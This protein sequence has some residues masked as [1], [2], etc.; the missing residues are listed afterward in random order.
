MAAMEDKLTDATLWNPS[1]PGLKVGRVL[2]RPLIIAGVDDPD[3]RYMKR[4][5]AQ[6]DAALLSKVQMQV[7]TSQ[8]DQQLLNQPRSTK[9]N[10]DADEGGDALVRGS[11]LPPNKA[12]GWKRVEIPDGAS[13]V[14]KLETPRATD[15]AEKLGM[16]A[17]EL[18]AASKED[19]LRH[20]GFKSPVGRAIP[21]EE[22]PRRIR[23]PMRIPTPLQPEPELDDGS[24][25]RR[26]RSVGPSVVISFSPAT[27]ASPEQPSSPSIR[28]AVIQSEAEAEHSSWEVTRRRV[29]Q[30]WHEE[31][32]RQRSDGSERDEL[33]GSDDFD[34]QVRI[35]RTFLSIAVRP[36]FT[37]A[38]RQFPVKISL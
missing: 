12:D 23:R 35:G 30:M 15:L 19:V 9:S 17:A 27:V 18:A 33:Q 34:L 3:W 20:L 28:A 24:E 31:F 13:T 32:D 37:I 10:A 22:T 1:K 21:I 11:S 8:E 26:A 25:L 14:W 6:Q 7:L 4:Q 29:E 38:G 5:Q 2:L 16:T 36:D